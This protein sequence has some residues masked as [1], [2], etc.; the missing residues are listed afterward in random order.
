[1][2]KTEKKKKTARGGAISFSFAS[3]RKFHRLVP[4]ASLVKGTWSKKKRRATY[5]AVY[6][7]VVCTKC[8]N[9]MGTRK[10]GFGQ[11]P[12]FKNVCMKPDLQSYQMTRCVCVACEQLICHRTWQKTCGVAHCVSATMGS[13]S[14][15]MTLLMTT[16]SARW[17]KKEKK[18][19]ST[20]THP[21]T[22]NCGNSRRSCQLRTGALLAWFQYETATH[23]RRFFYT[24]YCYTHAN[25]H[26][27]RSIRSFAFN[28]GSMQ[29]ATRHRQTP[30]TATNICGLLEMWSFIWSESDV[31][32]F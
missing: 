24:T 5:K 18:G 7:F 23:K 11:C 25:T 31:F 8:C 27:R 2:E 13:H 10:K 20:Q 15:G 17:M 21:S 4:L 12:S 3:L 19:R 16:I 6:I 14:R 26:T 32:Q 30:T 28:H 22:S 1:M 9:W 29:M